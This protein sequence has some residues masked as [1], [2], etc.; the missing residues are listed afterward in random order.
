MNFRYDYEGLNGP[1][2]AAVWHD[3]P[4][5]QYLMTA[6]AGTCEEGTS[7]IASAAVC[8]VARQRLS[9]NTITSAQLQ[10]RLEANESHPYA[11]VLFC[12]LE[13]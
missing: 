11:T 10:A 9:D 5:M 1:P 12:A 2:S 7:F 3:K 13:V 8:R 4:G 6:V